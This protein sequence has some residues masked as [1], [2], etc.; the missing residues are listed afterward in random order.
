MLAS[1]ILSGCANSLSHTIDNSNQS[2][3]QN[4]SPYRFVKIE[5]GSTHTTFQLEPAGSPQQTIA[6]SSKLLLADILKGL[7]QKCGF[8]KEDIVEIRKVKYEPPQFYEVW[9]FKDTLSKRADKRSA[10]SVILD[11]YPNGGGVDISFSDKCH[12]VPQQFTFTN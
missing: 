12:S 9:V 10:I 8:E 7:K 6:V 11:Q 3:E 4:K 2:F 5:K 1:F